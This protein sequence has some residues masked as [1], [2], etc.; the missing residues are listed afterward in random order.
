MIIG[1]IM[2]TVIT[3]LLLGAVVHFAEKA[4]RKVPG[5]RWIRFAVPLAVG[6]AAEAGTFWMSYK[7]INPL[8]YFKP[9]R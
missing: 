1:Y 7:G 2:Q 9:H 4:A 8:K 6:I 3:Y 5:P